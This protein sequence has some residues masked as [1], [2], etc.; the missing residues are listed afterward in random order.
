MVS[1]R[2]AGNDRSRFKAKAKWTND[3]ICRAK[4]IEA[5]VGSLLLELPMHLDEA[6]LLPQE[7]NLVFD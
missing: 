1:P 7:W 2:M 3:N 4:A 5:E 6:W